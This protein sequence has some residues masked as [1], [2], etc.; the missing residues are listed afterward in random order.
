MYT[1]DSFLKQ[2]KTLDKPYLVYNN[3]T[4]SYRC[5]F[6]WVTELSNTLVRVNATNQNI[7][8][9]AANSPEYI[10][11]YFAIIFSGS[12]NIPVNVKGF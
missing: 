8:I 4:L 11:S 1:I 9:F 12:T 5:V 6:N 2:W 7:A 10:I 3:K